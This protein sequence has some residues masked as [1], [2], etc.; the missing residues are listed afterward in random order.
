MLYVLQSFIISLTVT[1]NISICL[2]IIQKKVIS[3]V[4]ILQY[5]QNQPTMLP[6]KQPPGLNTAESLCAG[7]L[8]LVIAL[9]TS[10]VDNRQIIFLKCSF[11]YPFFL[12]PHALS[13]FLK[14]LLLITSWSS[15]N[16]SPLFLSDLYCHTENFSPYF[17]LSLMNMQFTFTPCGTLFCWFRNLTQL[18]RF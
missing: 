5:M 1:K 9:I 16:A 4:S 8:T 3:I 6:H 12:I 2:G 13:S 14:I 15:L 18:F 7:I 11:S 10:D 17:C